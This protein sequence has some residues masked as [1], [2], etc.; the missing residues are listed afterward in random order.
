M[1]TFTSTRLNLLDKFNR[2]VFELTEWFCILLS[3]LY[4]FQFFVS[5]KRILLPGLPCLM[6]HRGCSYKE[7]IVY[8]AVSSHNNKKQYCS[9]RKL[10]QW[11]KAKVHHQLSW[12]P[13]APSSSYIHWIKLLHSHRA[14]W[15]GAWQ[16]TCFCTHSHTCTIHSGVLAHRHVY[17]DTLYWMLYHGLVEEATR[18]GCWV[19]FE[20][21]YSVHRGVPSKSLF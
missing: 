2:A 13:Y 12:R 17:V 3:M 15:V 7:Q 11:V 19:G 5:W 6:F 4:F 1:F 9:V 14:V 16:P 21:V 8:G 20:F 10:T 18:N